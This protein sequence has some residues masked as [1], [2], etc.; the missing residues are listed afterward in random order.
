MQI[1]VL[2]FA[3]KSNITIFLWSGATYECGPI[4]CTPNRKLSALEVPHH[5]CN[6]QSYPVTWTR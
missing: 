1:L 3:L 4:W 2:R 6:Y 5:G